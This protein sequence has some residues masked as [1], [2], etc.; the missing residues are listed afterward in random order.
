MQAL[1]NF[2]N[3][4]E[5]LLKANEL[6]A[7]ALLSSVRFKALGEFKKRL[8]IVAD[9]TFYAGRYRLRDWQS[10][11]TTKKEK[12]IF[13]NAEE[14]LILEEKTVKGKAPELEL[15]FEN[16]DRYPNCI[17]L[18][19]LTRL[20]ENQGF[21]EINCNISLS[22]QEGLKLR[23]LLSKSGLFFENVSFNVK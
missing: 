22:G 18:Y 8:S 15:I 16:A 4:K 10:Y 12:A 7:L 19:I 2:Y 14:S 3:L 9:I 11:D 17:F 1:K 6:E 21:S 13:F 23:E 20:E 5:R